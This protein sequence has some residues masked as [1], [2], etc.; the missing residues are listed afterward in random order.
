VAKNKLSESIYEFNHLFTDEDNNLE[1]Q[2]GYENS[3]IK[4]KELHDI[5]FL[6]L[7]DEETLSIF[8]W[9]DE[10]K[11]MLSQDIKLLLADFI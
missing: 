3:H 11:D 2:Y 5:I 1:Q 6:K 9:S 8:D 10:S 4:V 7:E